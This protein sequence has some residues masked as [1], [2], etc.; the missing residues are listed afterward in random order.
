MALT[1]DWVRNAVV[2]KLASMKYRPHAIK[3]RSEHGVDIKARHE[4]FSRYFLVEVKGEPS[5]GVKSASAGR[6]VRFLQGLGQLITRIQP[7]RGYYYGLAFPTSYRDTVIRRLRPALLKLLKVHL[8]FVDDR[9]RVE[10]LTWR[11][12]PMK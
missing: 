4:R 5:D 11:E 6:E 8:F 1:E 12:L 9:H 2:T 7:E 3:S 10:H